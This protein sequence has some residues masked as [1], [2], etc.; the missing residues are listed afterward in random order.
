MVGVYIMK[1]MLVYHP[2][3]EVLLHDVLGLLVPRVLAYVV[4]NAEA[5]HLLLG[6][7]DEEQRVVD[8]LLLEEEFAVVLNVCVI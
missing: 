2:H 8:D 4:D 5:D 7:D 3:L 6:V 1:I